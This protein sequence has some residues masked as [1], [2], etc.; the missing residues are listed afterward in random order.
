[1]AKDI[2]QNPNVAD[3]F[4]ENVAKEGDNAIAIGNYT[5][6]SGNASVAQGVGAFTKGDA[7]IALGSL[8]HTTEKAAQSVAIGT[9]AD[10]KSVV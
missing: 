8:A 4:I 1:M 10:R 3:N 9:G 7:S 5:S 6:A 2:I